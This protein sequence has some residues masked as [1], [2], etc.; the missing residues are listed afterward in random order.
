M[1]VETCFIE[2]GFI[3]IKT[4]STGSFRLVNEDYQ[5]PFRCDLCT[6]YEQVTSNKDV[7]AVYKYLITFI[8]FIIHNVTALVRGVRY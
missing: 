2:N 4:R 1:P 7:N 5:R 8:H 6:E 3:Y